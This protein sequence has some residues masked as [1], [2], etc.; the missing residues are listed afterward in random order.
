M[1]C[2]IQYFYIKQRIYTQSLSFL[3]RKNILVSI[4]FLLASSPFVDFTYSYKYF[5][6]FINP[7]FS[8]SL[9]TFRCC[10]FHS[11]CKS[12]LIWYKNND[13]NR[14]YSNGKS[15]NTN[16]NDNMRT[17]KKNPAITKFA[18]QLQLLKYEGK[19]VSLGQ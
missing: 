4:Y 16:D 14:Y 3:W 10:F 5:V 11:C 9:Y 18:S 19:F 15:S 2:L 8:F 17:K 1:I 12:K 13:V 7:L 6:F